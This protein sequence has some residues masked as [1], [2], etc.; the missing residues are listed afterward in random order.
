[1]SRR[2]SVEILGLSSFVERH[3]ATV[4]TDLGSNCDDFGVRLVR[5]ELNPPIGDTKQGELSRFLSAGQ[6]CLAF[7]A[8]VLTGHFGLLRLVKWERAGL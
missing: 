4:R 3:E 6:C 1:M 5:V 8:G 7:G 2:V